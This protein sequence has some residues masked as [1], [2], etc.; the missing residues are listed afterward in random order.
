MNLSK[1]IIATC[2]SLSLAVGLFA[3]TNT[4]EGSNNESLKKVDFIL[5]WTPN[6]NHTGLFVAKEKGYLKEVGIDLDIKQ[7]SEDST[8]DLIINNKAPFGIYFQDTMASK[9]S[10]K[11]PN[12]SRCSHHRAQHLGDCFSQRQK[13]SLSKR[14][15]K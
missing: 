12:H 9:L 1:K 11:C 6:T 15:G 8:S 7:P 13:H 2:L 5:D 3:C 4:P 10:K 14:Y